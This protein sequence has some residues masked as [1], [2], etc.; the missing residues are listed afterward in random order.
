MA[1]SALHL[2]RVLV[3]VLTALTAVLVGGCGGGD[4]GQGGAAA[5]TAAAENA[6]Q[7][8]KADLDAAFEASFEETGA[9][10]VVAAVQTPGYTWEGVRGVADLDTREP[11]TTDVHQRVGSVTKTFTGTLLLQ[12]EAKGLLSLDDT[13]DQYIKDV[14]NGDEITLRQLAD[15]TSGLSSYTFDEGFQDEL[16]SHPGRERKPE[17]LVR[18]GLES[19]PAFDPGTEFLYSNTNTVL[20]GLVLQRAT[21]RPIGELYREQIIEPLGLRGTSFPDAADSSLPDPHAQGYTLQGQEDGKPAAATDWNPSWGFAAGAMI[22]TL[23]DLLVYGRALGTGE[24]LLP[25][26]QQAERLGSFPG[27]DVPPNTAER[28]YGLGIGREYGWL[29]HTG[30]LPGYNTAVYYHPDLDATVVVEVNS[31]IPSGDC[32]DDMPT[33][34]DGPRGI[35][36]ANPA[37]RIFGALAGALGKPTQDPSQ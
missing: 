7:A 25:P 34:S 29:G 14:P 19:P 35:P 24:G 21:G 28:A 10:G 3:L 13:I 9:P 12:A 36:C 8:P 11:M 20:L 4:S 30:E 27:E 26:E 23:D 6:A 37:V 18:I 16:F 31:D 1:R 15:M 5:G 22:S 2:K 32:P 33:M 17:E